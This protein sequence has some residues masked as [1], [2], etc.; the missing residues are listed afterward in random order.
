MTSLEFNN[1]I[2]EFFGL[3]GHCTAVLQFEMQWWKSYQ[4]V[5]QALWVFF[6]LVFMNA[7]TVLYLFGQLSNMEIGICVPCIHAGVAGRDPP[8]SMVSHTCI[9]DS[10]ARILDDFS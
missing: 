3:M 7:V 6:L 5:I 10:N 4:Q 1:S 9:L 8:S 2:W